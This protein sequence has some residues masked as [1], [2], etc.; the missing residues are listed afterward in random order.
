MKCT[1][2]ELAGTGKVF[3]F[4]LVQFLKNKG[5]TITLLIMLLVSLLSVPVMTLFSGGGIAAA[6]KTGIS[7]VYWNNETAYDI[8]PAAEA[9]QNPYYDTEMF[10]KSVSSEEEFLDKEENSVWARFAEDPQTGGVRI[11]IFSLPEESPSDADLTD[12][13]TL[14]TRA[15]DR[16]RLEAAGLSDD[17]QE[18]MLGGISSN[19]QSASDYQ[20]KEEADWDVQY[21]IQLG[22]SILVMIVSIFA[23]T[24]IIRTVV[25]EK[26]SKLVEMLVVSVQPLALIVGKILAAMT[27][28]FGF[29][30]VMAAGA[31]VS[32]TVTGKFLDTT[33]LTASM[34]ASGFSLELLKLGPVTIVVIVISLF[35][36]FLTFSIVAGLSGAGCSAME[37]I[38]GA[39]MLSTILIFIG[40]FA[41]IMLT[42]AGGSTF[43]LFSSLCPIVSAFSAPVH[44]VLGN[45]SFGILLVSW[46]IQAVVIAFLAVFSARVYR[47]LLMYRG[48]RPTFLQIF[49]MAKEQ[50][51]GKENRQH[52]K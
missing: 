46:A 49:A 32:W 15:A 7:H 6:E 9:E 39:S 37:D 36:G 52:E 41:G 40:Y 28:I 16:A 4:T 43:A 5:N 45:I 48:S 19:I 13:E 50:P 33:A 10:S 14:L 27:Y 12:L 31:A 17:Q 2:N 8:D 22:Y 34:Q 29:L 51:S 21:G 23:V 20:K 18:L 47:A 26:A 38:Q 24:Y 42:S 11:E 44:Y 3:S 30:L 25:E 1:K 35:L